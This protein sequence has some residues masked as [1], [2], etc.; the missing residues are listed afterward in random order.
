[1]QKCIDVKDESNFLWFRGWQYDATLIVV[2]VPSKILL[3][4]IKSDETSKISVKFS[5]A[6]EP[7][8]PPTISNERYIRKI[9]GL[10]SERV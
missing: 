3:H 9:I 10:Y 2:S 8:E 4:N 7:K 1:M 5:A 6:E